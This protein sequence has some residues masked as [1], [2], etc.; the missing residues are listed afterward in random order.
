MPNFLKKKLMYIYD[1]NKYLNLVHIA[2]GMARE[3]KTNGQ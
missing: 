1:T 3:D 2:F